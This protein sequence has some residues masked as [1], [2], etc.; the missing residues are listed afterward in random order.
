MQFVTV[1]R[2]SS[3]RVQVVFSAAAVDTVRHVE[4]AQ[5]PEVVGSVSV[6]PEIADFKG[7]SRRMAFS[8]WTVISLVPRSS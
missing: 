1:S 3:Q 6:A 8:V 5:V 2:A 4:A 7:S